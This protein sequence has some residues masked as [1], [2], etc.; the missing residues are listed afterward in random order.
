LAKEAKDIQADPPVGVR[1]CPLSLIP[2]VG[3]A[4]PVEDNLLHW[5]ATILGPQ[6]SPYYNPCCMSLTRFRYEGGIFSLEIH[7][8]QTYPFSP[9]KIRFKTQIYHCNIDKAGNICLDTLK[10]AWYSRALTELIY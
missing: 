4:A 10:N 6:G 1:Y 5:Q 9:P 2:N 3:S 8:P 7:F